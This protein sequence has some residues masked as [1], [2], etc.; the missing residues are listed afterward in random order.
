MQ[1]EAGRRRGEE[2][3][4]EGRVELVLKSRSRRKEMSQLRFS[5]LNNHSGCIL[6]ELRNEYEEGS[7][8]RNQRKK[9]RRVAKSRAQKTHLPSRDTRPPI[10]LRR[11]HHSRDLQASSCLRSSRREL[12]REPI[13][14]R[15]EA[16]SPRLEGR[17]RRTTLRTDETMSA[18]TRKRGKRDETFTHNLV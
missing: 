11:F 6:T 4:E 3:G 7:N 17:R 12:S 8:E 18:R 10:P 5:R 15:W 14:R 1:E 16:A 2:G 13:G 9:R